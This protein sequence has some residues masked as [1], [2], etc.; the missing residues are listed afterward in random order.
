[1][2]VNENSGNPIGIISRPHL[3]F[4]V[5]L[6]SV[7]FIL[8]SA[9]NPPIRY[10]GYVTLNSSLASNGTNVSVSSP[11]LLLKTASVPSGNNPAG[12]YSLQFEL[13]E[14]I[15]LIFRVNGVNATSPAPLAT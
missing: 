7:F 12:Y 10:W 11:S 15:D 8:A 5:V 2:Q 1:M 9:S 6:F 4:L 14:G 3:F 13:T